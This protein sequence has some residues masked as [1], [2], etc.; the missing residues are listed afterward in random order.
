[1]V[2]VQCR[3]IKMAKHSEARCAPIPAGVGNQSV[4][5]LGDQSISNSRSFVG[6]R[7][8]RPQAGAMKQ[9]QRI[10][11]NILAGALG[12]GLG[13]LLQLPAIVFI[14]RSVGVTVFGTYSFILAFSMFFQL[15][16]DSGLSNILVRELAT[17]PERMG[18]ILGAAMLLIWVLSFVVGALL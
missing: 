18:E 17:K 10:V 3:A 14:A 15:L 8:L 4:R 13:G 2:G 16:A 11:K 7:E 6:R 9:S 12:V 1:C 5:F